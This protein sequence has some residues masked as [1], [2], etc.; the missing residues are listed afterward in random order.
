MGIHVPT[1][2]N[3]QQ[4]SGK[5]HAGNTPF[6]QPALSPTTNGILQRNL[7]HRPDPSFRSIPQGVITRA[8]FDQ[9]MMDYFG[10][11][12]IHTGTQAQQEASLTRHGR[13]APTIP[14]WQSW[15][16]GTASADYAHIIRAIEDV[17]ET[18]GAIP[19]IHT[20]AFFKMDY[21]PN[22]AGIGIA[23]RDV[24]ASFGGG[25]LTIFEAFSRSHA[26]PNARSDTGGSYPSAAVVLAPAP[27]ETPGA[28][29]PYQSREHS[30]RENIA[31]ELGHGIAEDAHRADPDVFD[32]FNRA[33]G[34][35][36]GQLFDIG[37]QAVADAISNGTPPPSQYRIPHDDWNNPQ[38]IEQPMSRYAVAGGPGEDFAETIAAYVYSPAVLLQRSPERYRFITA[39]IGT[40]ATQMRVL[41][42]P[43][44]RGDFPVND[45]IRHMA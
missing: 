44:L 8:E 33:I 38:W 27:G 34:W 39:H 22:A 18:F 2:K 23:R 45:E 9:Y 19:T 41:P 20:V 35:V 17:A 12:D 25:K 13:P 10:V 11:R 1:H 14:H 43:V 7:Q 28:P 30:L 24:G 6:F 31:H 36:G 4:A 26:F 42:P 32:K 21:D 40:W 15:D 5:S 37:Q 29:V 3:R 16:P